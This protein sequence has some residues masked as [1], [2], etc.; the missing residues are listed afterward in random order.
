MS[1]TQLRLAFPGTDLFA[2]R[3]IRTGVRLQPHAY[4]ALQG[5]L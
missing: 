5:Y 1:L 4:C 3:H 2:I